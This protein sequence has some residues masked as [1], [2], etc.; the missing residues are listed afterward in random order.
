VFIVKTTVIY[1]L[2]HGLCARTLSALPRSTQPSNLRGTLNECQ[3]S[4]MV[5]VDD[6][7]AYRRTHSPGRV[8]WSEGRRPLG[9]VLHSS[10]EPSEL[11]Q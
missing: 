3:F 9:A 7:A 4:A 2:G 1:S 5:I 6:I 10:R 11:S 8:A